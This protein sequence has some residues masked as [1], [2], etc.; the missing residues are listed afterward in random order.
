MWNR[1][2]ELLEIRE[3]IDAVDRRIVKLYEE[4]MALATQVAEYKLSV[5][6]PVYDGERERSKLAELSAMAESAFTAK[7]IRELF[8]H[9]M[10]TS[11]NRQYQLMT[12]RGRKGAF[13]VLKEEHLELAGARVVY[14]GVEGAYSQQ[15]TREFF[16]A[17]AD[18]RNVDTW[19][20]AMEAIRK[21]EADYAVL[22]L[23]NSTAGIISENYDLLVEYDNY[24]IGEQVISIDHA[25][26]GNPGTSLTD[27]RQVYSHPQAL[28]QCASYLEKHREWEQISTKNTAV[29]AKRIK[30][31]GKPYQAA[32]AGKINA[33]LYGLQVLADGIQ[34]NKDNFTRFI[35]VTGRPIYTDHASRVSLCFEIPHESGALYRILGHFIYNGLNM[36]SIQ[37][38]PIRD[39]AW[40][41]RFFVEFEGRLD[42]TAVQTALNGISQE[43]IAMRILGTI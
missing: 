24:I 35:I 14:Q 38:R 26:L 8:E 28:L 20:E 18:S 39:R 32:I 13:G 33:E 40:E 11:R 43:T 36:T 15:A 27:I 41:Y 16:G 42:E 6:R 3:E 7:G 29:S 30:E 19:R 2:R 4:R 23:E 34:D 25:L 22:P 37:S 21:G 31:E 10:T 9:I 12:E 1:M 5:G 17:E